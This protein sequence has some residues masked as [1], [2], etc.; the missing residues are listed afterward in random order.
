[1][2]PRLVAKSTGRVGRTTPIQQGKGSALRA[3]LSG[4]EAVKAGQV[5]R[6]IIGLFTEAP[7]GCK[8]EPSGSKWID[9]SSIP[10][11]YY[12]NTVHVATARLS[13]EPSKRNPRRDRARRSVE[14]IG[15]FWLDNVEVVQGK[16]RLKPINNSLLTPG[17]GSA[18]VVESENGRRAITL[19]RHTVDDKAR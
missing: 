3:H 19:R 11:D 12:G 5:E 13:S 15:T 6:T 14:A 4:M 18:K 7:I 2:Q 16:A 8:A 1:M 17:Q 10:A 9:G